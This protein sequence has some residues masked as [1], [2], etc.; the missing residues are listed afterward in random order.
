M[1][2][3]QQ[4]LLPA[5]L[6]GLFLLPACSVSQKP[7]ST[8]TNLVPKD[9]E[10]F[11]KRFREVNIEDIDLTR[12]WEEVPSSSEERE[13]I[14]L[15]N[16]T[17]SELLN[18]VKGGVVNLYTMRVEEQDMRF[19]LSPNDIL[20]LRIPLLS[21]LIDIVP[22]KVP[23]PYRTEGI[24]LGSGFII[25]EEGYILTNAHVAA[26]ATDIRVVLSG[27]NAQIPAK[28]IGMDPVTDTALIKAEA[29]YPLQPLP[30]GDSD[31]L[32]VG[33]VVIAIGNPLG[34]TNTMTSG[35]I[36][37]KQRVL[38]D[39]NGR[40]LDFLQTDSAINPGSSGG[41][42]INL[43]GEVIGINTAI[44]SEA[45]LV[46][47]AIP[48]NTVKEVMPLLIT[49]NTQ[50]GWF[51]ASGI[52]LNPKDAVRLKYP[53]NSGILVKEIEPESPAEKSGLREDDIIIELN[54]QTMDDFLL[55]RRKL[56]GL[57]PGKTILLGVF[58]E[59]KIIDIEAKLIANPN[60]KQD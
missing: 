10:V 1:H 28:I 38:P 39:R 22:W 52:P 14:I 47:F 43:Y 45:Q 5:L 33:E 4:L 17:Y 18:E 48:M 46:G 7:Q 20:P 34:L 54:G 42:L 27:D 37:A 31:A 40:I 58:R 12:F 3:I 32:K 50:R 8:E 53:D 16:T 21:D 44:I 26:N 13:P 30:L 19:G 6:T 9:A 35:L 24:S 41:P 23:L 51:G 60:A 11:D 29:G 36:S 56:L 55:F 2:R 25:N 15:S 59:G 49:G 57:T